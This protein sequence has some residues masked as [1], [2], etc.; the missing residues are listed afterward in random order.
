[1]KLLYLGVGCFILIYVLYFITVIFNKKKMKTFLK[2]SQA[3]YFIIKYKLDEN[4]IN[5]K[6]L[7]NAIAIS[8][9]F[10]ISVTLIVT[11]FVKNY[12]LKLLVGLVTLFPLIIIIYTIIG[13]IYK[14]KEG[15]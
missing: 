11:E 2:T 13:K 8:N 3:K 5:P 12:F 7:A 1:M 4:K 10:I 6:S 15:R 14:K 9:S